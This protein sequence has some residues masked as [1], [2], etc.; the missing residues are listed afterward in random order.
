MPL[1]GMFQTYKETTGMLR[2]LEWSPP[3]AIVELT[4]TTRRQPLKLFPHSRA[5][6]NLL[7]S[8]T[9]LQ[10]LLACAV[11]GYPVNGDRI[12]NPAV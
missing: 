10:V 6:M 5:P 2:F 9:L 7:F 1:S 4:S 12:R 3:F 11:A 8:L